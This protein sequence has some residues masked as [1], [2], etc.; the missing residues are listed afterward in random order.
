L[1]NENNSGK[2]NKNLEKLIKIKKNLEK[3]CG[4]FFKKFKYIK[5]FKKYY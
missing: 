3:K 5:I 1:K 4:N 2:I